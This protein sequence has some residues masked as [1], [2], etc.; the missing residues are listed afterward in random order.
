[1][2][3]KVTIITNEVAK[4]ALP[5]ELFGVA[6]PHRVPHASFKK[7]IVAV[8]FAKQQVHSPTA[9]TCSF[10]SLVDP[11]DRDAMKKPQ[12]LDPMPD[13][14]RRRSRQTPRRRENVFFDRKRT[15][16]GVNHRG[17]VGGRV[18]DL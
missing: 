13:R 18:V 1:M 10:S 9:R 8:S 6:S 4:A 2:R 11:G 16:D 3:K 7:K 14:R 15:G 12:P 17:F 5:R